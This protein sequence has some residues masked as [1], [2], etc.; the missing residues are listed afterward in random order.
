MVGLSKDGEYR[1]KLDDN[2]GP[3][4]SIDYIWWRGY[5]NGGEYQCLKMA[6]GEAIKSR[7]NIDSWRIPV[8]RLSN[9]RERWSMLED[10]LW[11]GYQISMHGGPPISVD[12]M[13]IWWQGYQ[14]SEN[15][16]WCLNMTGGK[17]IKYRCLKTTSGKDI[18][19]QRILTLEDALSVHC[20]C[21][22]DYRR[23][24][25]TYR[26]PSPFCLLR[27]VAMLSNIGEY[28]C[29]EMT[30]PS[31]DTIWRVATIEDGSS[32]EPITWD[33]LENI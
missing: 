30:K 3:S 11:R 24:L 27:F 8:A 6:G 33:N 20:I 21:W 9:V 10:D 32:I 7:E 17:A 2:Q 12:Y 5:Q 1:S 31:I 26:G 16:N 22:Q 14:K 4:L 18:K 28:W 29:S 15:L 13:Y 25:R 19:S 23:V